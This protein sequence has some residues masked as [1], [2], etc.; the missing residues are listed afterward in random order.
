LI[1]ND[2]YNKEKVYFLSALSP[3]SPFIIFLSLKQ[4]HNFLP[5]NSYAVLCYV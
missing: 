1:K 5:S 2:E 3:L 4:S